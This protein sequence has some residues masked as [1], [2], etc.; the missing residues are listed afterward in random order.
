MSTESVREAILQQ[1]D[2]LTPEQQRSL[3]DYARSLQTIPAG[4][5]GQV[6]L[7]HMQEFKFEP[8]EVDDMMRAIDEACE[9]ID[10]DEW[11]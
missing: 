11:K 8:G 9:R 6:L 10:P 3:L 4:T 1:L 2:T 7:E 5:P